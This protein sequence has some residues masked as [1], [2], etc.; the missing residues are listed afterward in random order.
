MQSYTYPE[1][2]KGKERL[3]ITE[4]LSFLKQQFSLDDFTEVHSKQRI[5]GLNLVNLKLKISSGEF[6]RRVKELKSDPKRLPKC[7][8][9]DF[10]FAQLKAQENKTAKKKKEEASRSD[11]I[12]KE[13]KME[14][15]LIK[16]RSEETKRLK[17]IYLSLPPEDQ[18]KIQKEAKSKLEGMNLFEEKE[19]ENNRLA[20][21]ENILQGSI[22]K[23]THSL[24]GESLDML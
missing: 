19:K 6:E 16:Q 7:N 20:S 11:G 18:D 2:T 10:I 13:K 12:A 17:T 24:Y 4:M 14:D 8:S 1:K 5:C 15:E 23:I 9:L 22:L 3:D 21:Y